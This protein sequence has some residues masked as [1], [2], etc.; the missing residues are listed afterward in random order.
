MQGKNRVDS[1]TQPTSKMHLGTA[2]NDVLRKFSKMGSAMRSRL[3][4]AVASLL[5]VGFVISGSLW[6]M[7]ATD[8]D[9]VVAEISGNW[10]IDFAEP[11]KNY[12]ETILVNITHDGDEIT[13]TALDPDLIKASIE[14]TADK[15]SVE[16]LCEPSRRAPDSVFTGTVTG[17]DAMEGTWE[18]TKKKHLFARRRRG[19]WSARRLAANEVPEINFDGSTELDFTM[20]TDEYKM[21]GPYPRVHKVEEGYEVRISVDNLRRDYQH[22][23]DLNQIDGQTFP[24]L[25]QDRRRMQS[26]IQE[27]LNQ[28]G[29]PWSLDPSSRTLLIPE[30]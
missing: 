29:Y 13:G 24:E 7:S 10:V 16:F 8:S 2:K 23:G 28:S 1:A 18:L 5:V 14:G 6:M 15:G 27:F 11:R 20:S 17:E 26:R 12:K 9:A 21:F 19:T 30:D 22:L 4:A 3:S 25:A